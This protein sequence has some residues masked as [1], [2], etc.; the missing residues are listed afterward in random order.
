MFL[1][2]YYYIICMIIITIIYCIYT[3]WICILYYFSFLFN[4]K[5]EVLYKHGFLHYFNANETFWFNFSL[6]LF[7]WKKVWSGFGLT[8]NINH[9]HYHVQHG[10]KCYWLITVITHSTSHIQGH[11][12]TMGVPLFSINQNQHKRV[13]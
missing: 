9:N 11:D 6:S 12:I 2:V 4:N 7:T 1:I 3:Y 5:T 8:L 13:R 10:F